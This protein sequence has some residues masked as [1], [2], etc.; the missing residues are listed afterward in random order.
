MQIQNIFL[1]FV[2]WP[3]NGQFLPRNLDW[4][5]HSHMTR[6]SGSPQSIG[7]QLFEGQMTKTKKIFSFYEK[8]CLCDK[9]VGAVAV[10]NSVDKFHDFRL[11]TYGKPRSVWKTVKKQPLEGWMT[12][13]IFFSSST[14][15]FA[16]INLNIVEKT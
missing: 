6:A 11:K 2:I 7:N 4:F 14:G 13:T 12:K 1:V 3:S 9:K 8:S 5:W 15:D 16:H 10:P